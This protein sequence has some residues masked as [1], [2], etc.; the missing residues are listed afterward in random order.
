MK[1]DFLHG[2][3]SVRFIYYS[4]RDSSYF[5]I[6][7]VALIILM[8]IALTANFVI[9]QLQN[10]FVIRDE[11]IA[12]RERIATIN[13][14]IS[15][16]ESLNQSDIE[17]KRQTALKALPVEKDF[18]SVINA[19]SA[20]SMKSGIAVNDFSFGLGPISSSS[21]Q[22]KKSS[23]YDTVIMTLSLKGNIESVKNFIRELGHKLPLSK[24]ETVDSGE[25]VT[26]ITLGF[27]TKTYRAAALQYDQAVD[28]ISSADN[29]LLNTLSGYEAD[30][31]NLAPQPVQRSDS[32]PVF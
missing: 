6:S 23:D 1:K 22:K 16:L 30:I 12:T 18:A 13:N 15:L 9:P 26:T 2:Q 28:P 31:Q 5:T 3:N 19:I 27:Y 20:S 4:Y 29:T 21:G 32:I 10:W 17:N 24:I 8:V 14:N 7:V 11:T 25:D